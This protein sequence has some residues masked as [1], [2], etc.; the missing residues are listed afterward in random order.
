MAS[1]REIEAQAKALAPIFSRVIEQAKSDLRA[2]FNQQVAERDER[3]KD[4]EKQL[5][6]NLIDESAIIERILEAIPKPVDGENGKDGA[7]ADPD[8]IKEMVAEAVAQIP[9][10]DN[11]KDGCDGIDGKDGVSPS[12]EE[13]AAC[14]E[15]QFSD[16]QLSWERQAR[17][18]VERAIDRIPLPSDGKDGRDAFDIGDLDIN[19]AQDGRTLEFKFSQGEN[20][21]EKSIRLPI[22]IDCGQYRSGNTYERGDGVSFG[23]S[24]WIAQCETDQKPGLDKSWRLATKKGRDGK[25]YRPPGSEE[26]L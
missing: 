7:D 18:S 8:F 21:V 26:G 22:P 11:G 15:R 19:L 4:L 6:E 10:P 16:L 24:F 12:A 9:V 20:Q 5:S 17:E 2:E 3:I 1:M 13:V 25:T 14:F 23:G